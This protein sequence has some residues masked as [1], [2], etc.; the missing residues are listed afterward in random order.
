[1]DLEIKL[2]NKCKEIEEDFNKFLEIKKGSPK[3]KRS[4][5]GDTLDDEK[6]DKNS[7]KAED[8][9][10]DSESDPSLSRYNS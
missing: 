10:D 2:R 9:D 4:T 7:E 1:M 5:E 3:E 6:D 8:N